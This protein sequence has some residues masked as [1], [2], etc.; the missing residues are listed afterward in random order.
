MGDD[1]YG[2]T[3]RPGGRAPWERYPADEAEQP[4]G[5]RNRHADDATNG[6]VP[7]SVQD[8]VEKVDN[9]RKGRRRRR[10]ES[11]T[12][13]IDAWDAE[14][15]N[16]SRGTTASRGVNGARGAD[17]HG[18]RRAV[19][20]TGARRAVPTEV[21]GLGGGADSAPVRRPAPGESGAIR[22]PAPM[23]SAPTRRPAPADSTPTRRPAPVDSTPTRRPAPGESGAIRRP[24]PGESGAIGRQGPADS[25]A[26]RRPPP[27]ESGAARQSP[28]DSGAVRRPPPGESGAMARQAPA[29]SAPVRRAPWGKGEGAANAGAAG[30]V[31]AAAADPVTE[32]LPPVTGPAPE[33]EEPRPIRGVASPA[34]YPTTALPT[35]VGA[36]PL[37]RL[38]GNRQRR[39]KRLR[40]AGRS[41]AAVVA[42]IALLVTGGGWSYLKAK[43]NG[44][45][46][47]SALDENS[48]D[49]IDANAQF[50]DETFL[51]V[52]T[53]TRAGVN[54]ELGAGTTEDAEGARADTVMLVNIPAKRDR[55]VAVSFPRDLDVTRPVCEGWDNEEA[56]YSSES[57]PSAIGDKLNATYALGGPK[58][59]TK[60]IQKMTGLK[61]NHFVG[62]DFAGF[63]AMVDT[64]GGVEVCTT[65]PLIDDTLGTILTEPG[66][67]IVNGATALDYVR[68]RHVYG[69]ERSD[70]DRINRQQRFLASLLRGA[71]SS[72]V[73]FDLGKLNG[74]INGFAQHSF[75]DNVN[76]KDLLTLG[77]SLQKVDAGAITFLTIPTAGT[78]SY[79]N[80]IPRESDIKAI[81]QAIIDDQPLPGEKKPEPEETSTTQAPPTKPKL[82]AVDPSMVSLQVSNGSGISGIASTTATKLANQGFQ[83]YSTGNYAEGSSTTTKVRYSGSDQE[84][85]AATV[86]SAIP[87][88]SL[89]STTGLGSI[90]EVVLGS[91]FTGTV[92]T[93]TTFGQTLPDAPA[94]TAEETPIT[95]PSDLEHVNAADDTCK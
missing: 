74:F 87:G 73:L 45:N 95:L 41:T 30:P 90:V 12:P 91:D 93:P 48:A 14:P 37:S 79:G 66:K 10:A 22:R 81:F 70:Y 25:G 58:C 29:D 89:E 84:A 19:D 24:A 78:T 8:L 44:F 34:D 15:T 38:A 40:L 72:K 56:K 94:S 59:L 82:T 51:I 2:R 36:K 3:P 50:G 4:R 28:A 57:F 13:E 61:I 53:D 65:K 60:V 17:A 71:L 39:S 64:I 21:N 43:D 23:D 92:K 35:A 80:E 62:I 9:E 76:T 86:A 69:E 54:S 85:A 6:S 68:A 63:E 52:G 16:G 67:Q 27:G 49:I 11:D 1:R 31:R 42:V 33:P 55:V 32:E 77:R 47:V 18:A 83:I 88:A 26:V 7:I 20:Q 46:Q 75:M 5:R